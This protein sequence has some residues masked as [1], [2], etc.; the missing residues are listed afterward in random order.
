MASLAKPRFSPAEYLTLERQAEYKSEYVSG[1]IFAMAGTSYRHTIIVANLLRELGRQLRGGPCRAVA[2]DLRVMV[3]ATRA[4]T[5]PDVVIVCG[6]P[7][8]SDDYLDTL[9]NPTVLIEVLSDSTEAF[10]R[11]GKFAHYRRLESLQEYVLITQSLMR[12]EH[13]VRDGES[14]VLT[15]LNTSDDVLTLASVNATASLPDIYED[16]E[17]G[18]PMNIQA[19]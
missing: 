4:Y 11:G 15:E 3:Q 12:V 19:I 1:E 18:P 2:N 6:Q 17:L 8:F 16:I 5:Y 7:Q 9:L 10:D 14:W 13:F